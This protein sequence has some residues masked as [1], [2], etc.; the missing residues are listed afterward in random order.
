MAVLHHWEVDTI[1][2]GWVRPFEGASFTVDHFTATVQGEQFPDGRVVGTIGIYV[3]DGQPVT[4]HEARMIAAAMIQAADELER[5][6]GD[7]PPFM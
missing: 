5:V 2:G 1:E 7:Q 3:R 6:T 4:A